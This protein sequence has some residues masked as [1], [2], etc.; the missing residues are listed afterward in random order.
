M[1]LR[2]LDLLTIQQ[3]AC[4]LEKQPDHK[5]ARQQTGFGNTIAVE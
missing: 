3:L 2:P 4:T 5:K 1:E